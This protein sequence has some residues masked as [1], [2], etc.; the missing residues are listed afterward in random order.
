MSEIKAD[1]WLERTVKNFAPDDG[2]TEWHSGD[3]APLYPGYYERC[4]TD[5]I[6]KHYW[7]GALWRHNEQSIASHWRQVGDYPAWRGITRKYKDALDDIDILF[8][9]N[10]LIKRCKKNNRVVTISLKPKS[11]L[12]MGN[13]EMVFDLRRTRGAA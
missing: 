4:Y 7:D 8:M 10:D 2:M 13:Y 6:Y 3:V 11:P 12:A 5:G 9:A 1:Y